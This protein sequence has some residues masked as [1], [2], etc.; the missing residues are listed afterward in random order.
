VQEGLLT[1]PRLR[2][3]PLL[4]CSL[5]RSLVSTT[6][7]EVVYGIS[8]KRRTVLAC[9]RGVDVAVGVA[10]ALQTASWRSS[11]DR[12]ELPRTENKIGQTDK[13]TN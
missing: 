3:G 12:A 5:S 1:E 2:R 6:R 4:S 8:R 11:C 13:Q 7:C 10:V 9:Y